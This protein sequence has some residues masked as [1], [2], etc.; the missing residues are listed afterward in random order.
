MASNFSSLSGVVL[1]ACWYGAGRVSHFEFINNDA[2]LG[3]ED[4]SWVHYSEAAPREADEGIN[5]NFWFDL[6]DPGASVSFTWVY[7]LRAEDLVT[8]MGQVRVCA[9]VRVR[10]CVCVRTCAY[11]CIRVRV[12]TQSNL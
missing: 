8:A 2:T 5:L 6:L 12:C 1:L 3:W 4:E 9:C 10:A 11:V 7:I